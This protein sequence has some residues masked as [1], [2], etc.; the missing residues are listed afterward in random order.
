[1]QRKLW[2]IWVG[3]T[4]VGLGLGGGAA[5]FVSSAIE[6]QNGLNNALFSPRWQISVGFSFGAPA[7]LAQYFVLRQFVPESIRWLAP[8][9]IGLA[10]G[11]VG[12]AFAGMA[13]VTWMLVLVAGCQ[14]TATDV[15]LASAMFLLFPAAGGSGGAVVGGLMGTLLRL[16]DREWLQ[17]WTWPLVR[18]WAGS[19]ATFAVLVLLLLTEQSLNR[20]GLLDATASSASISL[21]GTAGVA[22]GLVGGALSAR[23]FV[24]AVGRH[25]P[26]G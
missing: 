22:A 11:A 5:E 12:G 14:L 26:T 4:A 8:A 7:L 17:D 24:L 10:I 2:M 15:C 3:S 25:R 18:A 13:I 21:A 16:N 9:T 1:M 23:Q 6:G 20:S 19:G